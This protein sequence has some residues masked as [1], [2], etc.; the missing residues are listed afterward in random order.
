MTTSEN[1]PDP[2]PSPGPPAGDFIIIAIRNDTNTN[3]EFYRVHVDPAKRH[4]NRA[5]DRNYIANGSPVMAIRN[6]AHQ[7]PVSCEP[8]NHPDRFNG[9]LAYRQHIASYERGPN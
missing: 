8:G 5:I 6:S 7:W 1:N 3:D 2:A 9:L 4:L